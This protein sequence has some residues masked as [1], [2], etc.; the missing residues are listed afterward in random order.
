MSNKKLIES[1][2]QSLLTDNIAV[3]VVDSF[4]DK[5]KLTEI[6]KT[7]FNGSLN[8]APTAINRYYMRDFLMPERWLGHNSLPPG[9]TAHPVDWFYEQ[10]LTREQLIECYDCVFDTIHSDGFK[11][12]EM[13]D[14]I[15]NKD[16]NFLKKPLKGWRDSLSNKLSEMGFD[17]DELRMKSMTEIKQPETK[18]AESIELKIGD[19]LVAKRNCKTDS[20]CIFAFGGIEYPIKCTGN[21]Q[22]GIN[23]EIATVH[24]FSTIEQDRTYWGNFFTLKRS[25]KSTIHIE[26]INESEEFAQPNLNTPIIKQS[27]DLGCARGELPFPKYVKLLK[28]ETG[29]WYK[30][31]VGSVFPVVGESGNLWKVSYK[32]NSNEYFIGKPDCIPCEANGHVLPEYVKVM[33]ATENTDWYAELIG[34]WHRVIK[35]NQYDGYMVYMK[36]DKNGLDIRIDDCIPCDANGNPI[37][38]YVKV[39]SSDDSRWY[40]SYIGEVFKLDVEHPYSSTPDYVHVY[41]D[42]GVSRTIRKSDCVLCDANGNLLVEPST[43]ISYNKV[44]NQCIPV[45]KSDYGAVQKIDPTIEIEARELWRMVYTSR[46]N[47]ENRNTKADIA[48]ADYLKRFK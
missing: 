19:V 8:H 18:V 35:R 37:P 4:T 42:D 15:Y 34:S 41:S 14:L 40:E 6:V 38:E 47:S 24:M 21:N 27:A 5:E 25:P 44:D 33:K 13:R 23:S 48:Y 26:L 36:D 11:E 29:C 22:V 46:L 45:A 9:F 12:S 28:A 7:A 1:K 2:V 32:G 20:G 17:F 31:N 30:N 43:E 3:E 10:E 16:Y 39:M